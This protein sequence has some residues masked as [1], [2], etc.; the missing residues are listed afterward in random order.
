MQTTHQREC[1]PRGLPRTWDSYAKARPDECDRGVYRRAGS[2][3]P[4]A[5]LVLRMPPNRIATE[6]SSRTHEL[7]Q[8]VPIENPRC[9]IPFGDKVFMPHTSILDPH[10][11]CS[12]PLATCTSHL[13]SRDAVGT[14]Y[15]SPPR[16]RITVAYRD[17]SS[18]KTKRS[19]AVKS[20]GQ[21]RGW[22]RQR[23]EQQQKS[24][25]A[26]LFSQLASP[27]NFQ[28]AFLSNSLFFL[29]N[30]LFFPTRPF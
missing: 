3:Q 2:F 15:T 26:R 11:G 25:G 21:L 13:V 29:P 20:T 16:A 17:G 24:R 14:L 27:S 1:S 22:R 8:A 4:S 6:A 23:L 30:S 9:Q 5:L 18:P 12:A 19:S 10:V 7:C 28:L